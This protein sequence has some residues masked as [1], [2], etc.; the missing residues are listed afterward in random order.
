MA[1]CRKEIKVRI[2]EVETEGEFYPLIFNG[3]SCGKT[4]KMQDMIEHNK[5][6]VKDGKIVFDEYEEVL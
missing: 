5:Q 4:K 3:R 2:V 1:F 6:L